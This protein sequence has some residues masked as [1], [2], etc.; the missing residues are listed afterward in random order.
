MCHCFNNIPAHG[1]VAI[2]SSLLGIVFFILMRIPIPGEFFAPFFY[3][4]CSLQ[5]IGILITFWAMRP[6]AD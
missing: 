3:I 6:S 4:G 5:G 1:M 2:V